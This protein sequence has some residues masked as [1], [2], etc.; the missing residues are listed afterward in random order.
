MDKF[1]LL[2]RKPA[3]E[4][5]PEVLVGYV[6]P[7]VPSVA[8]FARCRRVWAPDCRVETSKGLE[9]APN[10]GHTALLS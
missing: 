5:T 3:K 6:G 8:S 9:K 7:Y 4:P 10:A 2:T 1:S